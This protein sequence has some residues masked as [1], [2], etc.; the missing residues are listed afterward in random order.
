VS[1][2]A[3]PRWLRD[4]V[5][6]R[7]GGRC[8]Y[9]RLLQFGQSATFHV[10]HIIP[11]AKGGPTVIDNLVLQCPYCSLHKAD[12]TQGADPGTNEWVGLF[13]PLQAEW[14]DHFELGPYGQISGITSIGRATVNALDMNAPNPLLARWLQIL[15]RLLD[16]S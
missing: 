13:H 7:D 11:R 9:C 5:L 2:S 16:P 1:A 10:D 14:T 6:Q 3:I 4:D 12:K 8:Q 15:H